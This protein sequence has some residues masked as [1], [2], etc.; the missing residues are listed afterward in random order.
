[1][2]AIAFPAVAD[3]S[4]DGPALSLHQRMLE[5]SRELA[6]QRAEIERLR[7]QVD[8]MELSQRGRGLSGEASMQDN[9]A[10][11]ARTVAEEAQRKASATATDE[12]ARVAQS[13]QDGTVQIG[14][15]QRDEDAQRREQEKAL[16]VREHAPLFQR[17]F[18]FDAGFS[19]SYYDRRQLALSGFLA[20]DA[21]F[22]GSINLD[23]TKATVGT[24]E[25]TGRYGLTDRL[26]VEASVPYVYRDSRFVSGGAGGASSVVS[27]VSLRSQGLGDASAAVYYQWV[28]ESPR[29]PDIVTSLRV[30]APTGRDPFGLK[31]IQPDDDNN[32]LNI[33]EE[34]PTGSGVWSATFNVS[35]LRTYDPV[36]LFGNIGYTYNQPTDFDDISP[37]ME[38]V[39]PAEVALGNTIQ[40]SGGLAIALNDRSAISFSVATAQTGATHTTAPGGPKRRVPGSSSNS[41]TLNIG[42]SYVLPSGWTLNGQLAAGLTPDAPNFVFSMRGSKSF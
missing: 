10:K 7:Q 1:M 4:D 19:Y 14:Q 21:I 17:K 34:L 35:A 22:L 16:V 41:T 38:Q 40:L 42:A 23:Q 2:L 26:S 39:S 25:L 36:I 11:V 32:N 33:P 31:L 6:T 9:A 13:A 18:T 27:E 29:W 24:L 15:T 5:M 8:E 30:R 20:L 3:E 37:V 12:E 28:K